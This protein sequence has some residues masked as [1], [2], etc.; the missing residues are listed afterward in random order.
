MKLRIVALRQVDSDVLGE[1]GSPLA[2]PKYIL[3]LIVHTPHP[4]S[5]KC[6]QAKLYRDT[7]ENVTEKLINFT[8]QFDT[9]LGFKTFLAFSTDPATLFVTSKL[10]LWNK[11]A[12]AWHSG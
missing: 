3:S 1:N 9:L 5:F 12:F 11:S 6:L 2:V 4:F 7:T 8:A 10:S